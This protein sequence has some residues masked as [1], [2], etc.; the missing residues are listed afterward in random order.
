MENSVRFN[1]DVLDAIRAIDPLH[2]K[3]LVKQSFSEDCDFNR[4]NRLIYDYFKDYTPLQVANDYISMVRDMRTAMEYFEEH[5]TYPCKSEKD[6]YERVYSDP[7]VMDQYMNALMVSQVLWAHHFDMLT[8][9]TETVKMYGD[10]GEGERILDI[11]AGHGFYSKAILDYMPNIKF[12]DVIDISNTSLMM[13]QRVLGTDKVR[14]IR[15]S[16]FDFEFY[17][18]HDIVILG[19]VLE[20]LDNPLIMLEYIKDNLLADDGMMWITV[21]TNAPTID[22]VYLFR[23]EDEVLALINKAG[24]EVAMTNSTWADKTQLIGMFCFKK[25]L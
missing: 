20:H 4:L 8:F 13:A 14:Y 23:S 17:F 5:G 7:K 11:G 3:T 12:I 21:P 18:K 10:E 15:S 2:Y 1:L 19:E 6:A 24:L 16:I 9:F 22:H 25:D